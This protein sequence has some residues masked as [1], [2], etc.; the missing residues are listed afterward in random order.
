MGVIELERS[1][2]GG[3]VVAIFFVIRVL[4]VLSDMHAGGCLRFLQSAAVFARA[5]TFMRK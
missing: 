4:D 3:E 1:A 5:C 2:E